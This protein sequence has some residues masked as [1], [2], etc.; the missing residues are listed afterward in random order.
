MHPV[1]TLTI[2]AS[3]IVGMAVSFVSPEIGMTLSLL[4]IAV[5]ENQRREQSAGKHRGE[6]P[7]AA[8]TNAYGMTFLYTNAAGYGVGTPVA[9]SRFLGV[10]V[11]QVDNTTGADGDLYCETIEDGKVLV[12]FDAA[13]LTQAD[14]GVLAYGLHNNGM[15]KTVAPT[16]PR[17]GKISKIVSANLAWVSLEPFTD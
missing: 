9:G 14:L 12:E 3:L 6:V 16:T 11:D 17:C 10:V 1:R 8:G 5:T 15:T 7:L 13:D 2:V 4:G